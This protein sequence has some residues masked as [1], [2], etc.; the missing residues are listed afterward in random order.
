MAA[1]LLPP[2]DM[3]F[4]SPNLADTWRK[5]IQSWE[6]Y[7]VATGVSDKTRKVQRATFLHVIG[8][9]GQ[10]INS[11]F[12]YE[13]ENPEV[14][15]VIK[16]FEE[17]CIPRTNETYDRYV[18]RNLTQNGR[19]FEVFLTE[20]RTKAKQCGYGT[21][22][23]SLIRDQII[24]GIDDRVTRERLLRESNL[25]LETAASVCRAAEQSKIQSKQFI[26]GAAASVSASTDDHVDAV[27]QSRSRNYESRSYE[28]RSGD[29][30]SHHHPPPRRF[31]KYRPERQRRQSMSQRLY[32]DSCDKCGHRAHH[33]K[34][35][36]PAEG[37]KC[38]K[39]NERNHLA[40]CCRVRTVDNTEYE[41]YS[42]SSDSYSDNDRISAQVSFNADSIDSTYSVDNVQFSTVTSKI[43]LEKTVCVDFKIDTGAACNIIPLK[44][45]KKLN[46]V[47]IK[48]DANKLVAYGGN[49]LPVMG[50]CKLKV[51][52]G[53]KRIKAES[54]I[55]GYFCCGF[56]DRHWCGLQY[57]PS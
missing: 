48:H 49:S 55:F 40:R 5:W 6:M 2:R 26:T 43:I 51:K 8:P 56:Q 42:D 16:K 36:C 41:E 7:S 45:F 50:K 4:D 22:E 23:S 20:I 25:T 44:Y 54:Q 39:C 33:P 12:V 52:A 3:N 24:I 13:N 30:Y 29:R 21:L 32:R 31:D 14:K 35:R 34:E 17:Y 18:F 38:Y 19:T 57:Y 37:V 27:S 47:Q 11:T 53:T 10:E 1:S 15:D 46:K 9:R 28:P